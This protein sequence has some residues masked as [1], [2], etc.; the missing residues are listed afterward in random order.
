MHRLLTG[1]IIFLVL[2]APAVVLAHLDDGPPPPAQVVK[3]TEPP[4][5]TAASSEWRLTG[6]PLLV[7]LDYYEPS[8]PNTFFDGGTMIQVGTYQG[9]PVYTDKTVEPLSLVLVPIGGGV[10][11]RY[12]RR[13]EGE[14]AGTVGSR[15]SSVQPDAGLAAATTSSSSVSTTR[16][17]D[18]EIAAALAPPTVA[19]TPRT[20]ARKGI[21]VEFAGKTWQASGVRRPVVE[22]KRFVV[23]GRYHGFPVY[24]D[25]VRSN[26]IYIPSIAGGTVASGYVL[27]PATK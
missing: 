14:A 20:N 24:Q 13:R 9:V 4:Q 10:M 8:G 26:Q 27:R 15:P 23:I 25:P 2:Q 21:S 1:A 6:E 18:A 19:R 11:K 5:V 16:P 3:P 7:G 12:E 17:T 22:T